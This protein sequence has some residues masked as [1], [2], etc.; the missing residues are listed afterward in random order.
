MQ[1]HLMSCHEQ[2][3]HDIP[4]GLVEV[5]ILCRHGMGLHVPS[6]H[7]HTVGV[8]SSHFTSCHD[9]LGNCD[10]TRLHA[11]F[12]QIIHCITGEYVSTDAAR[13]L[14]CHAARG[15][16]FQCD[17]ETRSYDDFFRCAMFHMKT[18]LLSGEPLIASHRER[19]EAARR[20]GGSAT[21]SENTRV[22]LD[23]I[24]FLIRSVDVAETHL[25]E[26]PMF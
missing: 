13:A 23:N 16:V 18:Q 15:F 21:P 7:H 11:M 12:H 24:A 8:M 1:Y 3:C 20:V 6:W 4:W 14:T 26:N 19:G 5:L 22:S 9:I 25:I 17:V 10:T 2:R